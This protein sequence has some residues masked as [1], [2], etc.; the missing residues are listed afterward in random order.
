VKLKL[1][2]A[3]FTKCLDLSSLV[4]KVLSAETTFG[5]TLQLKK[6]RKKFNFIWLNTDSSLQSSDPKW[7]DSSCVSTRKQIRSLDSWLNK[8]DSVKSL[9]TSTCFES[10]YIWIA[11]FPVSSGF[12]DLRKR[13]LHAICA[14][15][16]WYSRSCI[17]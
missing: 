11:Y 14:C 9:I 12:S 3:S 8:Y 2:K 5:T 13:W 17:S 7:L 10:L 16:E 6:H 4:T 15:T 1:G